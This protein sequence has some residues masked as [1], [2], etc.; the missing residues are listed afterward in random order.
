M[1]DQMDRR[2]YLGAMSGL[3][4]IPTQLMS[5]HDSEVSDES[6]HALP[7]LELVEHDTDWVKRQLRRHYGDD[8]NDDIYYLR[9]DVAT[10]APKQ[11]TPVRMRAD[12]VVDRPRPGYSA[13][14]YDCEDFAVHLYSSLTR[15]YP[16]LSVGLIWNLSGD[17]S[18]NIFLTEGGVMEY[19]P[20]L[21]T[22]SVVT[23]SDNEP[24][25]F[26]RGVLFL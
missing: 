21:E 6:P 10:R 13:D 24:Y 25:D 17:H 2:Q 22:D 16:R 11:K 23:N 14:E 18:Y 26:D 4:F 7:E 12:A 9:S 3:A 19:D 15:A 5:N 1:A 8:W 20:Q